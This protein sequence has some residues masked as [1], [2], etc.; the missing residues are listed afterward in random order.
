MEQKKSKKNVSK[1]QEKSHKTNKNNKYVKIKKNHFYI[2]LSILLIIIFGLILLLVYSY[3][4]NDETNQI[5]NLNDEK[6]NTINSEVDKSN[7]VAEFNKQKLTKDEFEKELDL[8]LFMQGVPE[9]YKSQ[10]SKD[11]L[12]NQTIILNLLYDEAISQNFSA[13]NE[14]IISLIEKSLLNTGQSLDDLKNNLIN[15][16][17]NFDDLVNYYKK[18]V[19]VNQYIN[20]TV[21]SKVTITEDEAKNYYDNNQ[22]LLMTKDEVRASHILVNSSQEAE[23]IIDKLN[24]GGNFSQLAKEYSIGPSASK[25]GDLGYFSSEK[26]VPEFSEAVVNID[27]IGDY[28]NEPVKTKFGYHI[29]LLTDRKPSRQLSYDEIDVQLTKQLEEQKK[30]LLLNN[31]IKNLM[32]KS[33][34]NIY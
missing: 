1:S 11:K 14:E 2:G 13:T 4:F 22:K 8:M 16:S 7:L 15:K 12:L 20:S 10:I 6:N 23:D 17:F 18:Q 3:N 30:N 26:M 34:I 24:N 28:T 29:I 27:E 21:F 5:L 32:D 25:G 19:L 33:D 9:T 31:Y